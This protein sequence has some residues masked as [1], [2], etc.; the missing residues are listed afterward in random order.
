MLASEEQ[1][2]NFAAQLGAVGMKSIKRFVI[3]A[4]GLSTLYAAPVH[5]ENW[6]YLAE[7]KNG[8]FQYDAANIQRSGNEADLWIKYAPTDGGISEVKELKML[9]RFDCEAKTSSVRRII[10]IDKTGKIKTDDS[11]DAPKA[12]DVDDNPVNLKMLSV[13]CAIPISEEELRNRTV[14]YERRKKQ[15]DQFLDDLKSGSEAAL[16]DRTTK[17]EQLERAIDNPKE[18][19]LGCV[20][21]DANGSRDFRISITNIIEPKGDY[22]TSFM[23]S[24][25]ASLEGELPPSLAVVYEVS[26]G[27]PPEDIWIWFRDTEVRL[28]KVAGGLASEY[29]GGLIKCEVLAGGGYLY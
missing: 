19:K 10:T 8:A 17:Y 2:A 1:S 6:V 4:L 9:V 15:V 7:D 14:E 28:H 22:G 3:S 5:A 25:S 13:A 12:T 11:G 18:I 26:Y 24:G 27:G 21:K 16:T 23:W 29:Q 20:F